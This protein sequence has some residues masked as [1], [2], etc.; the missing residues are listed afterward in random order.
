M[1]TELQRNF[2]FNLFMCKRHLKRSE[3]AYC[4]VHTV[5]LFRGS[6]EGVTR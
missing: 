3:E 4:D 1:N 5:G 2:T 6:K